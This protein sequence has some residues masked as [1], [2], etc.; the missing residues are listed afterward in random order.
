MIDPVLDMYQQRDAKMLA[1]ACAKDYYRPKEIRFRASELSK[2]P[3]EIYHR[4]VGDRPTPND[5]RL[6]DYGISGDA[7]HD[8]VRELLRRAGYTIGGIDFDTGGAQVETKSHIGEWMHKGE[9]IRIASRLDGLIEHDGKDALLEI[10]SLGYWKYNA[11]AKAWTAGGEARLLKHFMA[12]HASFIYQVEASMRTHDKEWSWIVLY[13][14]SAARTGIHSTR[15]DKKICGGLWYKRDDEFWESILDKCARIAG[16]VKRKAPL[17]P[18]ELPGSQ[19][20][21][22]CSYTYICHD[23]I[24]LR[25]R[26]IEPSVVYPYELEA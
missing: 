23:A 16:A 7:C 12:R 9:K 20:C 19:P 8:I 15:D 2:C 13:D 17:R 21:D 6:D 25:S 14:R 26:G 4:L 11:C 10:K 24:Q 1:E 18:A 22:W 5:A 3:R